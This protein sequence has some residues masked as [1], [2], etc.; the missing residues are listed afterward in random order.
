MA[1][2]WLWDLGVVIKKHAIYIVIIIIIVVI[3]KHILFDYFM[4]SFTS[5]NAVVTVSQNF[6]TNLIVFLERTQ[7]D[8]RK[9]GLLECNEF[10]LGD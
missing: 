2:C 10:A 9:N 7:T 6:N 1:V 4:A 8:K 5:T 3:S